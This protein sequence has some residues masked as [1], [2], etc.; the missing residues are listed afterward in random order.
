MTMYSTIQLLAA[1]GLIVASTA[2]AQ[3]PERALLSRM[4]PGYGV[5]ERFIPAGSAR[6]HPT[7]SIAAGERALLGQVDHRPIDPGHFTDAPIDGAGAL[8]GRRPSR[9]SLVP[10]GRAGRSSF[11]ADVRGDVITSASGEAE[12]GAVEAVDDTSSGFVVSL[13]V[14]GSQSAILL[15]RMGG[16][17]LDVGRY[18]ISDRGNGADEVVALVMT[19]PPTSPS[20]VFRGRSGWLVVTAASDGLLSGRFHVDGVGFLA[21]E[22]R[23][24]DRPVSVTG[25]FT[26]TATGS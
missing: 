26:A 9:I 21:A 19:G 22:P 4:Q 6:V 25:S 18:R 11:R 13:G 1:A 24:E 3:A 20:G 10:D 8:L 15:T 7:R 17:P 14:R 2:H 5:A 12:F 23:M 16:A